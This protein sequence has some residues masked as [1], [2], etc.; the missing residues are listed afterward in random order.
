MGLGATNLAIAE[1][2]AATCYHPGQGG[3]DRLRLTV[4]D[5]DLQ[6]ARARL[7]GQSPGLEEVATVLFRKM[8]GLDCRRAR[9]LQTL[10]AIERLQ[11]LTV[12][13][14]AIDDARN[15]A[16]GMRYRQA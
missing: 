1:Q 10:R 11:P 3:M 15:A 14:V 12:I 6:V 2:L 16:I 7:H 8:D 9:C 4:L 5:Y 13:L